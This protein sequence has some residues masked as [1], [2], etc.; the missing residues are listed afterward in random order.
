MCLYR[1]DIRFPMQNSLVPNTETEQTTYLVL[2]W[3]RALASTGGSR[4]V[5]CHNLGS[6]VARNVSRRAGRA[7]VGMP[8]APMRRTQVNACLGFRLDPAT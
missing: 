2:I 6:S 7:P 3:A 1:R 4:C 8:T 5:T